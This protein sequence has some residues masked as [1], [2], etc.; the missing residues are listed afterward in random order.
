MLRYFW[1]GLNF[2]RLSQL[3]QAV[4]DALRN[5][6]VGLDSFGMC[7]H[8]VRRVPAFLLQLFRRAPQYLRAL[9]FT[10]TKPFPVFPDVPS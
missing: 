3:D 6:H 9:A 4:C 1:S 5:Q 2:E 8:R 7:K 10:G